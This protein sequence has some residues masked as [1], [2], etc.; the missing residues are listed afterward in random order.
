MTAHQGISRLRAIAA[1]VAMTAYLYA[2]AGMAADTV[3]CRVIGV[4]DGDTIH[5]L[6]PSREDL[7]VRL[8]KIDA[9]E[10]RQDFGARAKQHLSDKVFGQDVALE[11]QSQDRYGRFVA[12][13]RAGGRDINRE[14]VVDGFA[15]VY[16]AYSSDPSYLKAEDVARSQNAGLWAGYKPIAPWEWRQGERDGP[17]NATQKGT[18]LYKFMGR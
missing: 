15:W 14:M 10:K 16:R 8:A 13:V 18:A 7:R 3:H 11:I 5:C 12:V 6:T 2:G 17:A 1:T 4:S 9:P